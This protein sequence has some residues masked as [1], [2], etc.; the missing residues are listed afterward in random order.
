METTFMERV[1][2][3][4]AAREAATEQRVDELASLSAHLSAATARWLELVWEMNEQGDSSDLLRFLAWRCGI[5][6]REA[7][8]FLR[9]AEA[10]QQLPLT[11]A[12]FGRGELT[13]TKVRTLTRVATEASE[14]GLLELAGALTASQLERALRAYRRVAAEDAAAAQEL[15]YV[16]YF[17]A[18]DG[19][20]FLRARL[21]AEDGTL[22]IRHSTWPANA[23][24]SGGVRSA[25]QRRA[26]SGGSRGRRL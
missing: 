20:L 2:E 6:G 12:A 5:T 24:S 23:C 16:D 21:A 17:F 11:R 8:E 4:V 19:S 9:V 13:F 14:E 18:D 1:R 7:R 3:G 26:P 10:L 25:W 15:E 22:L